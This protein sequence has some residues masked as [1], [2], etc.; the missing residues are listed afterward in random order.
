MQLRQF[1]GDE[2]GIDFLDLLM[3][4]VH[5]GIRHVSVPRGYVSDELKAEGIGFDASNLGY[6]K[7]HD[8]DMVA[9]PDMT[10][11]FVREHEGRTILHVLC[12]VELTEG[13]AFAQYPR[14]VARAAVEHLR[15]AGIADDA[16]MLVEL[17]FHVLDRVRYG[18]G[19]AQAFYQVQSAEGLG[20]EFDEL[21]RFAPQ[22]GY[23]RMAPHDR[24][25]TVRHEI[26]Q[27]MAAIGI[28]V[29]YHHHEVAASQLEIE[30]D[31]LPLARAADAVALAK[32]IVRSV[33][34]EHGLHVTFMPK[35]M[36]GLAGNGMHV[37]QYLERG[38]RTLFAGEARFGLTDLAL[39]YTAGLL[40]HS[41]SGSLLAFTNPSTNSYRRLVPGFEAPVAA[42]FAEASREASVRVP[43][44]LRPAERRLEYRTGD[45]S[46]NVHYALSAMLLAGADGIRRGADPVA[47][48]FDDPTN[49]RVFPLSLLAALDGLAADHAYLLPAFPRPLIDLWIR[50]KRQEAETV[51]R[52]PT[53]QEYELYFNV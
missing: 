40:E 6:A 19:L 39:A 48:G 22:H 46:A 9:V 20:P 37:H 16:R 2:S 36:A 38:G 35:P 53:P 44:Y 24:Y 52:A 7:T 41:L 21:P 5:G 28:P 33:V 49:G 10:T 23:H 3:L 34:A 11:A 18:S 17:E 29:K 26:V 32:W 42:T 30:L 50:L 8:S 25:E 31:L 12:D 4:D 15:T 45:A 47:L 43:G 27:A 13:G 51:Y 14:H 1:D